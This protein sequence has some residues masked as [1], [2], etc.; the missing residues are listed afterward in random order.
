MFVVHLVS[1]FKLVIKFALKFLVFRYAVRMVP[2]LFGD[3]FRATWP[4][5]VYFI[6]EIIPLIGFKSWKNCQ[7]VIENHR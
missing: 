1:F 5:I 7:E 3:G 4:I 2:D 6:C